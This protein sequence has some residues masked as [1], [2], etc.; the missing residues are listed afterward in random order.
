MLG[1]QSSSSSSSESESSSIEVSENEETYHTAE[2]VW[3]PNKNQQAEI[4]KKRKRNKKK[5]LGVY[6]KPKRIMPTE[7]KEKNSK[8]KQSKSKPGSK[9]AILSPS[10]TLFETHE[11]LISDLLDSM[12]Q[13][14]KVNFTF[15]NFF[16][17]FQPVENSFTELIELSS[18]QPSIQPFKSI[19]NLPLAKKVS[20]I[21]I[22]RIP[23]K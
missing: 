22:V 16:E 11:P 17:V 1:Q 6:Q 12:I 13:D 5:T 9:L 18:A 14:P 20:G 4:Y 3:K 23:K 8:P 21:T 15:D 19:I 2:G 10:S 7:P